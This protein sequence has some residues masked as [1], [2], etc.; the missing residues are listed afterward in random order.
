MEV[1]FVYI[2]IFSIFYILLPH[3]LVRRKLLNWLRSYDF[4]LLV[5][6]SGVKKVRIRY[7]NIHLNFY[8]VMIL[9]NPISVI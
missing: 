7:L 5:V 8:N 9:Q 6:I 2:R 1:C 3:K 4:T